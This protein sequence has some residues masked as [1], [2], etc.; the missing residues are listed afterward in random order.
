MNASIWIGSGGIVMRITKNLED[1]KRR[2]SAACKLA[3]RS[4]NEVAILAVSKGQNVD[5]IRAAT[6]AGLYSLGENYVREALEKI[7]QC[8]SVIEWHFIGRIQSNKTK[9]I[10]ENFSWVQTVASLQVAERLNRQRPGHLGPLNVCVQVASDS[11]L[12]H[13]GVKPDDAATLCGQITG[14]SNLRLRGLMTIPLPSSGINSQRVPFRLLHQLYE[15]LL[16]Q[17]FALDTLSMGMTAD[18]EAAVLEGCTMV[19][20]GTALF[21]PRQI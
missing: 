15:D 5:S 20:I 3:G 17:G 13:G 6:T 21:G 2:I 12:V 1:L 10:A 14:L 7:P 18:L 9:V 8:S 19:R 11:S 16:S 4:E